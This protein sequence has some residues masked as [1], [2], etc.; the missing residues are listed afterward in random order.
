[1]IPYPVQEASPSYAWAMTVPAIPGTF[2]PF[3]YSVTSCRVPGWARS[4]DTTAAS[5]AGVGICAG[6]SPEP[7][8]S[9]R[10]AIVAQW[11]WPA[12]ARPS[13]GPRPDAQ[14]TAAAP[15]AAAA[16]LPYL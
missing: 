10:T 8:G 2:T 13:D 14:V 15:N 16:P 6:P 3:P 1:M 5:C 4:A 9:T 7:N 11:P 12:P